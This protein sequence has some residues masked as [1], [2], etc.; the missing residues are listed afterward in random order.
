MVSSVSMLIV[1][2]VYFCLS[3]LDTKLGWL[4]GIWGQNTTMGAQSVLAEQY[5]VPTAEKRR[6]CAA[7]AESML[8]KL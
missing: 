1:H 7:R 4:G 2:V 3:Q 6:L 8:S 5:V